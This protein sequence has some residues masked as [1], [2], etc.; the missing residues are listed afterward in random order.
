MN[1][2]CTEKT[3]A[4]EVHT[5]ATRKV[6]EMFTVMQA[7]LRCARLFTPTQQHSHHNR[8]LSS[9]SKR[10]RKTCYDQL[11]SLTPL[12][13]SAT[14]GPFSSSVDFLCNF[15]P[16]TRGWSKIQ[17]GMSSLWL[18]DITP[19]QHRVTQQPIKR[20]LYQRLGIFL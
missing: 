2:P 14:A 10:W 3:S 9:A 12:N 5:C 7:E 15:R 16:M 19:E 4:S 1:K 13:C 20:H 8:K 11:F 17:R 18:S 6:K